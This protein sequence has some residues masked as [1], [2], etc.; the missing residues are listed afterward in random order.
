M[1]VDMTIDVDECVFLNKVIML[2]CI[3]RAL[4]IRIRGLSCPF[5][6]SNMRYNCPFMFFWHCLDA[7]LFF[8]K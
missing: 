2:M 4:S 6:L 7:I 8:L 5:M 3:T 1:L